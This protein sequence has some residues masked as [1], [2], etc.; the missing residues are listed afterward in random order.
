MEL[1]QAETPRVRP[2]RGGHVHGFGNTH[3]WLDP[4][5]AR[6]ITAAVLE[7]LARLASEDRT[8]F[9]AR[10]GAGAGPMTGAC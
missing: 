7:G 5:N 4:E 6:P 10:A 1:L 9:A 8:R 3:Y 2:E